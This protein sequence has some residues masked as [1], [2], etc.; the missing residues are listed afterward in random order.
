[1]PVVLEW[2]TIGLVAAGVI[3]LGKAIF[4][5]TPLSQIPGATQFWGAV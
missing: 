1:M 2:L 5:S 3:F 4:L